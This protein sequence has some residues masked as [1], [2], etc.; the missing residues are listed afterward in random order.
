MKRSSIPRSAASSCHGTRFEWCSISV[1]SRASPDFMFVRP[2]AW[3]IRLSASVLLRVNTTSRGEAAP[4]KR[5]S[6][7]RASS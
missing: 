2:Q 5:D 1:S 6:R 4:M 3:A 7:R